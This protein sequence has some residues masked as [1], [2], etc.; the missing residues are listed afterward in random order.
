[1]TNRYDVNETTLSLARRDLLHREL[2]QVPHKNRNLIVGYP[3][4][5]RNSYKTN[6]ENMSKKYF[7]SKSIQFPIVSF[8][9]ATTSESISISAYDFENLA[10]PQIFDSEW[11]QGGYIVKTPEGIF[12]N[13][14]E[15]NEIVLKSLL[16]KCTKVNDIY[17]GEN[18]F[19][20]APYNSFKTGSQDCDTFCEGG[21]AR[22]L[23]STNGKTAKNLKKIASPKIYP[24]G[25]YV[26]GSNDK[27]IISGVLCLCSSG[28][29]LDY[30]R[31]IVECGCDLSLSSA[32][33]GYAFGVL[34]EDD[35][36]NSQK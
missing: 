32:N 22:V 23:E 19:G 27:Q 35:K 15:T 24:A 5:G 6:L 4:F 8:R 16:D 11:L 31:F 33:Q 7:N 14:L 29:L 10:K 34:K 18:D 13:T 30:G 28:K 20:F 21:L 3:A 17:L 25:V 1:M 36:N 9:P 12:V 26:G 2:L